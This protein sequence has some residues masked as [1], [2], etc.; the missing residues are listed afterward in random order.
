MDKRKRRSRF[1]MLALVI[2]SISACT[3]KPVSFV[4]VRESRFR[5]EGEHG[6]RI[7]LPLSPESRERLM[8][9]F[10]SNGD[11]LSVSTIADPDA[12]R[13]Y[14]DLLDALGDSRN[15]VL[16]DDMSKHIFCDVAA[17]LCRHTNLFAKRQNIR[18]VIDAREKSPPKID[19]IT[20]NDEAYWWVFSHHQVNHQN[21]FTEVL[22][23]KAIPLRMKR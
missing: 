13:K 19:P 4:A 23:M 6:E 12:E 8:K 3:P 2:L 9:F 18:Q 10:K 20:V 1:V 17:E 21:L 14:R 15:L 5:C 11:N 22:V 7:K 16:G